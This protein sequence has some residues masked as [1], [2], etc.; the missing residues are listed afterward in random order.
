[1]SNC[2]LGIKMIVNMVMKKHIFRT[3]IGVGLILLI[4][5]FGNIY[6]E[7]WNWGPMDF[8][9]MGGLLFITGMSISLAASNI[10]NLTL[11][12]ITIIGIV[13]AFI[14]IWTELAVDAVSR[15]LAFI[16]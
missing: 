1:M 5:V 12:A 9:F 15:L 7:G 6:V 13:M 8:L 4:P 16:F 14:A 3:V 2:N 10:T 11:R